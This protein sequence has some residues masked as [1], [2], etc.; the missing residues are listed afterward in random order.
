MSGR[1]V[2]RLAGVGILGALVAAGGAGIWVF[3]QEA[4]TP[5]FKSRVDLVVLSFTVTD[6]KGKYVNGLKPADFKIMEDGIPEKLA[7]FSEGS[8]PAMQILPDGS[9]KPLLPNAPEAR[10]VGVVTTG[11]PGDAF[12][13]TNVFVLFDTSNFM[14]RGFV[15]AE[16]AIADFVRGL[17]RADSVA[18]YT[19]S[20][21]LS[22]AASLTGDRNDA[23][24]GLRKAVAGDDTALYNGLLLTLR[25]AAKVPGRKVVIVFSNGPDNASMVAPDDVRAVAEDEGIPIYVI[26]TN[27]VNKD[28]ISSSVF[29]RIAQ[30]T[31]GKAYW[32]RTWQKQ[33][34]A[35]DQIR[36]D[37]G[38]SYTVTYYPAANPNEGFR[39]IAIQI[40][41]DTAKHYRVQSRPGY[42][43]R[44]Y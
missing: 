26:S 44:S 40:V 31:G 28:P 22:R 7:T 35:F 27:D 42:R 3:A 10:E 33:V 14:Y 13:G 9:M 25:D 16:D 11:Q 18:V 38:N 8:R 4:P 43:P 20:R 2:N 24:T 1:T 30:R 41:S 21:N 17:D 15:Y 36:E 37:L 5:V 6:N 34:E 39:K 12:V 19:F 29:R 32:A 23:I